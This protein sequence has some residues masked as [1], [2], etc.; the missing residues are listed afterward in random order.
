MCFH[1]KQHNKSYCEWQKQQKSKLPFVITG[2]VEGSVHPAFPLQISEETK[3]LFLLQTVKEVRF[4]SF[5][6]LSR[7]PQNSAISNAEINTIHS[8]NRANHVCEKFNRIGPL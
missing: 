6:I 5:L 4:Y 7:S 3:Q 8:A 1:L 2:L